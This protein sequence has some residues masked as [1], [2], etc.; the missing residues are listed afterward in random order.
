MLRFF[1]SYSVYMLIDL[2]LEALAEV[3]VLRSKMGLKI[4]V[5]LT[6]EVSESMKL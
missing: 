5:P 2:N 3:W 6:H 1:M 4:S